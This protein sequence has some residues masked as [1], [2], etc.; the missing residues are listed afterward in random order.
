MRKKKKNRNFSPDIELL[1]AAN[2]K[3]MEHFYQ[4]SQEEREKILAAITE[5]NEIVDDA[6]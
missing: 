2:G 4:V 6:K 3:S 1:I 5:T